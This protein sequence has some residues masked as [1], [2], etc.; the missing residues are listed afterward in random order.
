MNMMFYYLILSLLL[1][2]TSLSQAAI[3]C[4][5]NKDGARVC[6]NH[7]PPEYAQ[8]GYEKRDKHG[9]VVEHI[10]R[11]KTPEEVAEENRKINLV[12]VL[13][14][15]QEKQR[16]EDKSLLDL[17][18]NEEDINI[19]LSARVRTIGAAKNSIQTYANSLK[20][21]LADIKES[22]NSLSKKTNPSALD[23]KD[24]KKAKADKIKVEQRIKNSEDTMRQKEEE[25]EA[26]KQEFSNYIERFR[27]I[28]ARQARA[29][30]TVPKQTPQVATGISQQGVTKML[31]EPDLVV[32][33]VLWEYGEVWYYFSGLT[34]TFDEHQRVKTVD[35]LEL[36]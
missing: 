1:L 8:K 24:L 10:A 4:W 34:L 9:N 2:T 29:K 32:P 19:A 30:E 25:K 20:R 3:T 22:I 23:R 5:T 7:I 31:N 16:Q 28:K 13:K 11:A 36:K 15:Q 21:N 26:V 35:V 14:K 18:S 33:A 17:Y 12:K 6:G 27:L